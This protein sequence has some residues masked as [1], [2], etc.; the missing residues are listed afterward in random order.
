M[1]FSDD[2]LVIR[3]RKRYLQCFVICPMK[4]QSQVVGYIQDKKRFEDMAKM[5]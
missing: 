2:G 1:A 3:E 5:A 4:K